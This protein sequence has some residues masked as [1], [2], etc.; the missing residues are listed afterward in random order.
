MAIVKG[1][2][3]I[4]ITALDFDKTLAFYDKLGFKPMIS[5]GDKNTRAAMVNAGG[6]ACIE[7]FSSDGTNPRPQGLFQHIALAVDNCDEAF[8]VA[9]EAGGKE[10]KAPYNI[11]IQSAPEVTKVRIAF[12]FGPNG[13]EIEFFQY[14]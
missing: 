14:R 5:W 13:E 12:V 3:H 10:E 9:L 8:K 7:V 2:H 4:A 6:G 1:M 11:D